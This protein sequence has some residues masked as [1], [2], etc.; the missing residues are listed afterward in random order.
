MWW[1]N[2]SLI[3]LLAVRAEGQQAPAPA[4]IR[5][6]L[7]RINIE[8]PIITLGSCGEGGRGRLPFHKHTYIFLT[9]F[10]GEK[11]RRNICTL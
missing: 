4:N 1:R 6:I 11:K 5:E 10:L 7:S 2:I 8:R 3:F 9:L